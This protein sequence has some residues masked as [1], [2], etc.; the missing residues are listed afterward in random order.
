MDTYHE[1]SLPI[2]CRARRIFRRMIDVITIS[3]STK[4]PKRTGYNSLRLHSQTYLIPVP[5]P[6]P[7]L[8]LAV[9]KVRERRDCERGTSRLWGV[10]VM[11]SHF[12]TLYTFEMFSG[13]DVVPQT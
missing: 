6:A 11:Y 7:G 12:G 9:W 2:I 8:P 4:Y 1:N 13:C 5:S 10:S 3:S